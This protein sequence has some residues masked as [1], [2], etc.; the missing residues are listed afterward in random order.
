M[1]VGQLREEMSNAEFFEWWGF[2][3]WEARETKKEAKR[4][5]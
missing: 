1:T 3:D 2:L 5:G 4:R